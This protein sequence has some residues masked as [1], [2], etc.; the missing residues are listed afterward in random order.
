MSVQTAHRVYILS[1]SWMSGGFN[2]DVE[3][4]SSWNSEVGTGCWGQWALSKGTL[5]AP[6]GSPW[7]GA[8]LGMGL[9][10]DTAAK[11]D[12]PC[13]HWSLP[14]HGSKQEGIDRRWTLQGVILKHCNGEVKALGAPPAWLLLL[15]SKNCISI[16]RHIYI[17]YISSSLL[18]PHPPVST[19][20]R[21][22]LTIRLFLAHDWFCFICS[23]KRATFGRAYSLRSGPEV[24]QWVLSISWR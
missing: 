23:L 22:G 15:I 8:T 13:G 12:R 14:L 20:A 7:P 16:Y 5:P 9:V 2:K 3:D 4:L 21:A 24:W 1:N 6:R 18:H 10:W 17:F 11:A 19:L